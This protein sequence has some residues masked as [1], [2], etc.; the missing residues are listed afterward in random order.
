[1]CAPIECYAKL[2]SDIVKTVNEPIGNFLMQE[3]DSVLPCCAVAVA[4]P[5]AAVEQQYRWVF[6]NGLFSKKPAGLA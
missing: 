5:G 4:P 1:M 3:I 2:R 6:R